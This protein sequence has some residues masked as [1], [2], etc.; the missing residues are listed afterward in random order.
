MQFKYLITEFSLRSFSW[1]LAL[2]TCNPSYSG[3]KDQEDHGSKPAPKGAGVVAQGVSPG[4]KPQYSK[5]KKRMIFCHFA[6]M[7]HIAMWYESDF[8]YIR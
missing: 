2:H 1:A 4:F 7:P 6:K 3:C 5:N 8:C